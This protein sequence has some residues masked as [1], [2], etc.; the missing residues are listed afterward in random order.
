M[1]IQ[2]GVGPRGSRSVIKR[3][4][5]LHATPRLEA[6]VQILGTVALVNG[7]TVLTLLTHRAR[8]RIDFIVTRAG[9]LK[10]PAACQHDDQQERQTITQARSI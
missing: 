4:F 10:R 6:A 7:V 1:Q 3:T 8:A 2:V 5:A 9:Y